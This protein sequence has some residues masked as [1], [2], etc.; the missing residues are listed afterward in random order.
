MFFEYLALA[1]PGR[2][3]TV[4]GLFVTERLP[5]IWRSRAAGI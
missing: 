2:D 4:P 5:V 3:V 1:V